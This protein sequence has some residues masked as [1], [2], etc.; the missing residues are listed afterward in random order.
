M[1]KIIEFK[2][3]DNLEKE[4]E[5]LLEYNRQDR[6]TNF[7]MVYTIHDKDEKDPAFANRFWN[8]W[9]GDSTFLC[10]GMLSRVMDVINDWIKGDTYDE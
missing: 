10:L 9:F 2:K 1:K 7:V 4:I 8:Y 5:Q 6:V 3:P